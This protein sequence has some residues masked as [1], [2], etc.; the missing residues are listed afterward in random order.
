M[1]LLS[2]IAVLL[3]E[4]IRPAPYRLAV[5]APLSRLARFLESRFNGGERAH[6]AVAWGL[7]VGALAL[8]TAAVYFALRALNP[9]LGWLWSVLMLYLALGFRQ[10][11]HYYTDIQLA[12]RLNDLPHA[13]AVLAEWRGCPADDARSASDIARLAILQALESAH[14]HVF[15]VLPYFVLLGPC[16]AVLYR[17]AA[18]F[19]ASWDRGDA[20]DGDF[21]AFSRRAFTVIDWLPARLTAMA[22]AVVGNFENAV[23]CWRGRSVESA[24]GAAQEAAVAA[25]SGA[26]ALGM[27]PERLSG[28]MDDDAED[29]ADEI[30]VGHMEG[31]VGLVWR[32]LMLWLLMLL[33]LGLA[34]LVRL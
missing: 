9:L 30:D 23:Y 19:A 1:T 31:A 15:G 26:G 7:G 29:G 20:G 11:S 8:L 24:D 10:F 21:G 2:L 4:Q 16:G 27:R 12:L 33:L 25:A 18:F 32:A 22:F 13:R 6:G 28:G 34:G 3:L 5:H 17:A 14:T